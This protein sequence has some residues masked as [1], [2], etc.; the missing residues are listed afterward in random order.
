MSGNVIKRVKEYKYLGV[1]INRNLKWNAHIDSVVSKAKQK[2]YLIRRPLKFADS[3]TK[4]IA[5]KS[6][7]RATL[8]YANVMWYPHLYP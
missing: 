2:F 3:T 4:I 1:T 7:I 5:C 6:L 8:E